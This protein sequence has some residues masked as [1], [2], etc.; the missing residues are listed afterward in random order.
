MIYLNFIQPDG[1]VNRAEATEGQSVMQA[2]ISNLIPGVF[3][4]CGGELSCA[5]CHV[6]VDEKWAGKIPQIS[7]EEASMLEVTSE[8]PSVNSR[9]CCQIRLDTSMD[10]LVVHIPKSQKF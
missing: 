1:T 4:E 9:L 6:F 7:E 5:T 10:G 8:E 2:A 3:A